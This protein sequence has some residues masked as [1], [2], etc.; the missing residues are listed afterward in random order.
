[1]KI[2]E[3]AHF[4]HYNCDVCGL[5]KPFYLIDG[6]TIYGSWT[7]MCESCHVLFGVGLGTGKGQKYKRNDKED[8]IK[9]GG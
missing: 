1:M 6:R 5:K 3:K 2:G 7:L 4:S 9:I 8:Y